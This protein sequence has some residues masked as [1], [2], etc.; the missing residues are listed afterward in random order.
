[1]S[2]QLTFIIDSCSFF[3]SPESSLQ[4]CQGHN[5]G[6]EV[7]GAGDCTSVKSGDALSCVEVAHYLQWVSA[8]SA[9]GS[10][11]LDDYSSN[12]ERMRQQ[13]TS[14]GI[15]DS[16]GGRC[17]SNERRNETCAYED[18]SRDWGNQAESK[19][20]GKSNFWNDLW[21]GLG[22]GIVES[23]FVDLENTEGVCDY[24]QSEGT[25]WASLD[26]I[27]LSLECG[28]EVTNNETS[29]ETAVEASLLV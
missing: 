1:M 2:S 28:S 18:V 13:N 12:F 26:V 21:V 4:R 14:K 29:E 9:L 17:L 16:D 11:V 6:Q 27:N 23:L 3:N 22:L 24:A 5:G 25:D 19:H 15:A 20:A 7:D 8:H 10:I